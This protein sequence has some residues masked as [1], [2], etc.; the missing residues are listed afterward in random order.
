LSCC[1]DLGTLDYL[2]EMNLLMSLILYNVRRVQLM[3]PAICRIKTLRHLDISQP[4]E[5]HG[6]FVDENQALLNLVQNLPQLESLDISGTNL[7]G[8]GTV[9]LTL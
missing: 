3:I 2:D 7:A 8:T 4:K 5:K 6:K 9:N 1:D